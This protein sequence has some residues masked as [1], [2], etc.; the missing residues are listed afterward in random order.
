MHV[1]RPKQD[2]NAPN[3]RG[4]GHRTEE[5]SLKKVNAIVNMRT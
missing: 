4:V 3:G 5:T 1:V 2:D